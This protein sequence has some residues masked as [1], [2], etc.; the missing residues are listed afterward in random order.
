[1]KQELRSLLD[2]ERIGFSV[3]QL[4]HSP[5]ILVDAFMP[6][7]HSLASPVTDSADGEG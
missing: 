1:M 2:I 3:C 7:W 5:Q 6:V 4:N